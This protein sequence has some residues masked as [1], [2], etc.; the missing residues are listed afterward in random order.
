MDITN[1]SL[2]Y[3]LTEEEYTKSPYLTGLK[4]YSMN[5][6]VPMDDGAYV[7]ECSDDSF[8]DITYFLKYDRPN[9]T[10]ENYHMYELL[11]FPNT[12]G[13]PV[14]YFNAVLEDM[15]NLKDEER[16]RE[17]YEY[18]NR[19]TCSEERVRDVLNVLDQLAG[20]TSNIRADIVIYGDTLVRMIRGSPIDSVMIA[21]IP[22]RENGVTVDQFKEELKKLVQGREGRT[23]EDSTIISMDRLDVTISHTLYRSTYELIYSSNI[24]CLGICYQEDEGLIMTHK[25]NYALENLCNWV[26]PNLISDDYVDQLMRYAHIGFNVKLPSFQVDQSIELKEMCRKTLVNYML[27][28]SYNKDYVRRYQQPVKKLGIRLNHLLDLGDIIDVDDPSHASNYHLECIISCTGT[29][30]IVGYGDI[31]RLTGDRALFSTDYDL[32]R[33]LLNILILLGTRVRPKLSNIE[34]LIL[35]S[36]TGVH[37]LPLELIMIPSR[38]ANGEFKNYD[39]ICSLHSPKHRVEDVSVDDLREMYDTRLGYTS[40]EHDGLTRIRYNIYYVGTGGHGLRT[41][42]MPYGRTTPRLYS[43]T[44][45]V[46]LAECLLGYVEDLTLDQHNENVKS[47]KMIEYVRT[48]GSNIN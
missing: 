18:K 45:N 47:G 38:Q 31:R 40:D 44:Y 5:A 16:S 10:E 43:V 15:I 26:D 6:Q 3:H 8:E 30:T 39:P 11:G 19:F 14:D 20:L 41:M 34:R 13:Y 36:V 24:D 23:S 27:T 9:V 25:A 35:S 1:G 37:D 4:S 21:F 48:D 12:Y 2:R 33:D 42:K 29:S 17:I 7:L 46:R 22:Y 32:M 28:S